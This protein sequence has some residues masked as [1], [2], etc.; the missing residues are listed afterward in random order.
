MPEMK[1]KIEEQT[2]IEEKNNE[3]EI[4]ENPKKLDSFNHPVLVFDYKHRADG[5]NAPSIR[6]LGSYKGWQEIE[7]TVDSGACDTVMPLSLCSDIPRHGSEQQRSGMEYEVANGASI[8]NEGERRCLMMTKYANGPKRIVFQVA[9][10]HKALLSI[11]RIA[12]AGYEC[13]LGPRGG[14]LL[15]VH[16]G[17][18]VQIARK[19]Q[20]LRHEGVGQERP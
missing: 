20:T 15:D 13:H 4:E 17:E 1:T 7:V 14:C 3:A 5:M 11:T 6:A 18:S 12:D 8:R 16:T 9:D 10:V 19:R 2:M